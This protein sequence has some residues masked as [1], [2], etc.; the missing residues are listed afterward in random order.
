MKGCH[1]CAVADEIAE[2]RY[3]NA[4]WDEVPCST[5][6]VADR[7]GFSMEYDDDRETA[8]QDAGEDTSG[9]L[10]PVGVLAGF[11]EG[12]LKL[13]PPLRD[14][15]AMRYAGMKYA[16]IA[17]VQGVTMACVEK[18]HRQAM[19]LWPELR[20][21]F[22]MKASKQLRRKPHHKSAAFGNKQGVTGPNCGKTVRKQGAAAS[23]IRRGR[24]LP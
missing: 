14:V 1:D 2:G 11:V 12:F 24:R 9:Q 20:E 13:P 4:A 16:R 17:E 3:E 15:V 22:P 10:V 5:C 23:R 19:K 6:K 21:L 8:G 7:T 18:R